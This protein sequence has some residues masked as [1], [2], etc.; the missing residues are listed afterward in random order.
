M[1]IVIIRSQ[2]SLR[3][4]R[5]STRVKSSGSI[6]SVYSHKKIVEIRWIGRFQAFGIPFAMADTARKQ[7]L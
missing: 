5:V 7:A 4:H 3:S 2:S 1:M 6:N